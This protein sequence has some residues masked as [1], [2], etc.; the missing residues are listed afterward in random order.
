MAGRSAGGA[1]NSDVPP[2]TGAAGADSEAWWRGAAA[3]DSDDSGPGGADRRAADLATDLR[4]G[5]GTHGL[6]L[7]AG[8]GGAEGRS[9]GAPGV[10]RRAH[11]GGGRG[12]VA[13]FRH[14]PAR[15][16]DEVA[17]AAAQ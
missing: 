17:G 12:R 11:R 3:R 16:V 4:G 1:A 5:P 7:S 8:A 9:G 10:V 15:G 2:P 14:D 6:W 13:V